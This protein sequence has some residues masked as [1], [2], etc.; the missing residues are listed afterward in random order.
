[1]KQDNKLS[2]DDQRRG[3]QHLRFFATFLIVTG[4]AIFPPSVSAQIQTP[5]NTSCQRTSPMLIAPMMGRVGYGEMDGEGRWRQPALKATT[6]RQLA[7]M[8]DQLEPSGASG[9]VVLGYTLSIPLL[10]LFEEHS[11]NWRLDKRK[12]DFYLNIVRS[13][14]RP[15]VVALLGNHFS[16]S[17][18]LTRHLARNPAN[19]MWLANGMPPT[20]V[21][22]S[23]Q[24]HAFTLETDPNIPINR[25]R[26]QAMAAALKGLADIE[27]THP[28]R[29]RAVTLMGEVHHLFPDLKGGTGKFEKLQFTDYS[30]NSIQSFR[31]WLKRRFE[32]LEWLNE[33]AGTNFASWN[34][35]NPPSK[36]LRHDKPTSLQQHVDAYASGSV[37]VFGWLAS[38]RQA[39]RIE[40]YVNATLAGLAETGLS[41][42][43]V[44]EAVPEMAGA[45]SGYRYDLNYRQL[46]PGTHRIDVVWRKSEGQTVLLGTSDLQVA[47]RNG[48]LSGK[49]LRK[50]FD[51][52]GTLTI[53]TS[54][55]RGWLDHP[56]DQLDLYF[57]PWAALWQRFREDQVER[58]LVDTYNR[59]KTY[60]FPAD[61]LYSHQ[62]LPG[63][64]GSWNRML[65]AADRTN[66]AHSPY[67]K[68]L[69]LYG[70]ASFTPELARRVG[71]Q[72]FGIPEFNPLMGKH[73]DSA[74]NALRAFEDACADFIS[75]YFMDIDWDIPPGP[76]DGHETMLIHPLNM[77]KGANHFYRAIVQMI[78][79]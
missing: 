30:P 76:S 18:A 3:R 78:Q 42:L 14:P 56:R 2:M 69:T 22:F 61:R 75:P 40:V 54:G 33:A 68:G 58:F 38:G 39:P 46:P 23:T 45:G 51:E 4:I 25:L 28:G 26:F 63:K 57:N 65:F 21:Y 13:V 72:R 35:V 43:D 62:L 41:R 44:Y 47:D 17:S 24:V 7:H 16:P 29:V 77:N 37:P 53:A 12:L 9:E 32:R 50:A 66:Q 15:A 79:R 49:D 70:G 31:E 74:A 36:D 59:A 19:Y 27:R 64:N 60:G 67:A 55:E 71:W 1:V 34:D 8:L 48:D 52:K 73:P 10:W 11:G 20:S 5:G 6:A